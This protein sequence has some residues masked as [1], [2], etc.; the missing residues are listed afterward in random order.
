MRMI[1]LPVLLACFGLMLGAGAGWYLKPAPEGNLAGALVETALVEGDE[2]GQAAAQ[3]RALPAQ[4]IDAEPTDGAETGTEFVRLNNQFVVPVVS[5]SVVRSLVVMSLSLEVELGMRESVF[6]RE[7]KL[8]DALLQVMFD[9]AN[10]GG[11]D[12][13][14]TEAG[15]LDVLRAGLTETARKIVPGSVFGVLIVDLARQDF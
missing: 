15:N 5:D 2:T 11:F 14:F 3:S 8:R 12:G 7:P 4:S 9:H 1:L 10:I 6:Q 13:A